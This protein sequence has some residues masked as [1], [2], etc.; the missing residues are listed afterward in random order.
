MAIVALIGGVL[1]RSTGGWA[2]FHPRW[3]PVVANVVTLGLGILAAV[4]GSIAVLAVVVVA[5]AA[6]VV[7]ALSVQA[8]YGRRAGRS[9]R[10]PRVG[11]RNCSPTTT[12]CA[13]STP[14]PANSSASWRPTPPC[15]YQPITTPE[16]TT[17]VRASGMS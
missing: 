5:T 6:S 13:S 10:H 17:W 2:G 4:T 14:L 12:T 9:G 15:D 3:P 8:R 1:S 11:Q 16:H 7:T